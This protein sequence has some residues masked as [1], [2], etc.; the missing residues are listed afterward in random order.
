MRLG[1]AAFLFAIHAC[2]IVWG[3]NGKKRRFSVLYQT[4]LGIGTALTI[5][6]VIQATLTGYA[7]ALLTGMIL[8]LTADWWVKHV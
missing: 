6:A 7:A 4:L 5:A 1:V 8:R 2:V 3:T